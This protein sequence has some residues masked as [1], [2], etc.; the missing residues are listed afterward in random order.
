MSLRC[1]LVATAGMF[2]RPL[3]IVLVGAALS[4]LAD[5]IVGFVSPDLSRQIHGFL[6]L[7]P[8]IAE[9][10]TV[11]YLLV[12]GVRT[13]RSLPPAN[14]GAAVGVAASGRSLRVA[15]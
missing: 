7:L 11:V 6:A 2:P 9:G 8:A 3:G 1:L 14:E 12:W 13:S 4:Y 15:A 5:V 10:W